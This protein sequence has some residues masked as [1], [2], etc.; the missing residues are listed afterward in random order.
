[1]FPG[2]DNILKE[3]L[4]ASAPVAGPAWVGDIYAL[5]E[6]QEL[7]PVR[8]G[9]H[10]FI[11]GFTSPHFEALD[12]EF[13]GDFTRSWA[14]GHIPAAPSRLLKMAR[15]DA[16]H[17]LFNPETWK[18]GAPQQI[19]QFGQT[20]AE[21]TALHAQAF[22]DCKAYYFWA[23]S[24]KLERLYERSFR[25]VDRACLPGQFRPILGQIGDFHGY[26]RT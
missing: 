12:E 17:N 11:I 20:M 23:A 9:A 19:F 8:F 25:H 16:E 24:A 7:I 26:Q 22:P 10:D 6:N 18:L 13:L 3:A 5:N 15:A 2:V 14:E 21:A 1:V 4:F